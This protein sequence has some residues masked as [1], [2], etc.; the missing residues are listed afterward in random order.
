MSWTPLEGRTALVTGGAS[1]IG[2]EVVHVLAR[3]GARG[4]VID[5]RP[6]ADGLPGGW[7]THQADV[8]EDVAVRGA[9][10]AAA[11]S[12]GGLDVLVAAAGIVPPWRGLTGFDHQ[13]F[14]N[15][16]RL[17]ALG[18]ASTI[19]HAIPA[20]RDD[21]AIV[22]IAS[23]NAWRG[24]AN[25]PAYAASKHAVLGIVRSAALEL[26]PRGIRVNAV[27]PGPIATDA[28]LSRMATRAT[29]RGVPVEEALRLA[30]EGTALKRMAT[31]EEVANT[32]LFL[33]CDLSNGIT[34]HMIPVDAGIL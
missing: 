1:G 8:R 21:G 4:A 24:D 15:V 3:A 34:G 9:V 33:A 5:V 6:P 16:L 17:N 31:V 32:V 12:L 27:G 13:E 26:G 11:D 19:A 25:I 23:L 14:E 20:L 30:A 29:E 22:A 18:M 10:A 7:E 2:R 28:L